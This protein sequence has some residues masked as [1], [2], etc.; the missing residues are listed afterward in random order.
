MPPNL[1]PDAYKTFSVAAPRE[2]HWRRATCE[3][4]DCEAYQNGWATTV[5]PEANPAAVHYIRHDCGRRFTEERLE[6]GRIRWTFEPGQSCFGEHRAQTRPDL[7]L[8]RDGD[9]R[10]GANRCQLAVDDW[11]DTFRNHQDRLATRLQRG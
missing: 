10:W 1:R 6:D 2:T 8:V 9:W 4:S 7:F 3:E 11:V 5:D